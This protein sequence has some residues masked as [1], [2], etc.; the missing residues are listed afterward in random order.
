M[1]ANH[2]VEF[3]VVGHAGGLHVREGGQLL[4]DSLFPSPPS[5]PTTLTPPPAPSSTISNTPRNRPTPTTRFSHNS[6]LLA[7]LR[8]YEAASQRRLDELLGQMAQAQ[9]SFEMLMREFLTDHSNRAFTSFNLLIIFP[10]C[11]EIIKLLLHCLCFCI[12]ILLLIY[13]YIL[14]L[15]YKCIIYIVM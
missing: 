3:P 1:G 6:E 15:E 13:C 9:Q 11:D 10:K 12:I 5:A 7:L 14:L 4:V 8:E 2:D